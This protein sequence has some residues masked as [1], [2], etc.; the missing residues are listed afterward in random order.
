MSFLM[1][2]DFIF[3]HS[4]RVA[5]YVTWQH[6]LLN[7]LAPT[8]TWLMPYPVAW[9]LDFAFSC[10]HS[11]QLTSSLSL[12]SEEMTSNNMEKEECKILGCWSGYEEIPHIQG[13]K[14]SPSKMVGGAK[15]HLASNYIPARDAH[16]ARTNLVCTRIQGSHRDWARTVFGC[17]PWSY[18][19]AVACCRGRSSGCLRPGYGISPVG[20]G[21]Q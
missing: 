13:Q 21:H 14:R 3:W 1:T 7:Q 19:S 6:Q 12:P 10:C 18:R 16:R 17:L 20:G 11:W 5:P 2:W 9:Q 4:W 8:G 15:S